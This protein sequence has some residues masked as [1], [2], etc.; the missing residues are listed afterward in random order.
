MYEY[1]VAVVQIFCIYKKRRVVPMSHTIGHGNKKNVKYANLIE[2]TGE[3]KR[4]L[5]NLPS[6]CFSE[7]P[8]FFKMKNVVLICFWY[9]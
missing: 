5:R 8:V 4:R 7:S 9:T 6:L 1:S 2:C 3:I